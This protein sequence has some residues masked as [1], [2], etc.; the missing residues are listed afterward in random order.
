[1]ISLLYQKLQR[2]SIESAQEWM[3]RLQ[4]KGAKCEY[5]EYGSLLTE[6]L[7][8]GL[9]NEGM[10]DE[11]LR[12]PVVALEDTEESSIEHALI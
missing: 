10:T 1:M 11:I 6:Q 12:D 8:G 2:K 9:N 4:T 3:G 5:K 7:L